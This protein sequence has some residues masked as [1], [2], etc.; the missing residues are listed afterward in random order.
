M[1]IMKQRKIET[2]LAETVIEIA[3]RAVSL[4]DDL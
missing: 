1:G 2:A 3:R 4:L